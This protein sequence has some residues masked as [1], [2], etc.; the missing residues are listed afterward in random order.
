MN[1]KQYLLQF[2]YAWWTQPSALLILCT[3]QTLKHWVFKLRKLFIFSTEN[4]KKNLG[5]VLIFRLS[6]VESGDFFL[7]WGGVTLLQWEQW[8][9]SSRFTEF[10]GRGAIENW[11]LMK[12][13]IRIQQ[14]LVRGSGK[15]YFDTSIILVAFTPASPPPTPCPPQKI[16][17]DRSPLFVNIR[18]RNN[19]QLDCGLWWWIP[20]K[21]S[22]PLSPIYSLGYQ[23][24]I[25]SL[26]SQSPIYSLGSVWSCIYVYVY[27]YV[28]PFLF[29]PMYHNYKLAK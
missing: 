22:K 15:F 25:Y 17:N 9:I 11:P 13:I 10:K 1:G 26:G 7:F 4:G 8:G 12:G 27:L 29:I 3:T 14:S 19:S 28:I 16:N 23:S 2:K 18:L 20:P 5:A 24:P 21:L 6:R